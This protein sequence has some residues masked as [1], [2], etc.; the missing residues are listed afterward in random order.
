MEK[1]QT[2]RMFEKG[3]IT[4]LQK[5]VVTLESRTHEKIER[6]SCKY[7]LK[8]KCIDLLMTMHVFRALNEI[9]NHITTISL[10]TEDVFII[11]FFRN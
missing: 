3:Y 1:L 11:I 5:R 2:S 7:T 6:K 9:S 10:D 4:K 8:K